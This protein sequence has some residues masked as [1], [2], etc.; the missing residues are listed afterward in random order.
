MTYEYMQEKRYNLEKYNNFYVLEFGDD[1][2]NE[3]TSETLIATNKP[4]NSDRELLK[5]WNQIEPELYFVYGH[6]IDFYEVAVSV[7]D[8]DSTMA[9]YIDIMEG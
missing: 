5:Y 8:D 6:V 1:E 2:T 7:G 4:I 9:T 3:F